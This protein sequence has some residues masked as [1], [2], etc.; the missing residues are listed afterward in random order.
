MSFI[1]LNGVIAMGQTTATDF[2]A[3]DC[4][5]TSHN[6]FTE[7][8]A[9]NVIV[10]VWVEPC[11]GCISD[12]KAAY[13]AAMSFATSNPGI[14]H[15]WL[16]DDIGNTDCSSL[17]AWAN[18]NRIVPLNINIFDNA[19]NAIDQN[20]YGGVGMPHVVV[21][22]GTSHQI[23][24]N[25]LSGSNDGVA[26]TNA[27]TQALHPTGIRQVTN[28]NSGLKLF[29]NPAKDN[30]SFSYN[31]EE[32]ATVS[33]EIYDIAGIRVKT[34]TPGKQISGQ[35]S[36]DIHFDKKLSDGAY[37]LKIKTNNASQTIK[38]TVTD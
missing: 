24:Y 28:T 19:G 16:S 36:M 3:N 18:T 13:D 38:F 7:L 4:Y 21:L 35:H 23:F 22:G 2:T 26:I 25:Q 37:F 14:V 15:Y 12:A 11:V 31:L 29:P 9:G 8:N 20:N 17:S 27:I 30:I 32:A 10:L 1:L 33:V 34:I 6:L 5:S